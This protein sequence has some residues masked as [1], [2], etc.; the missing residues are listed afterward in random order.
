MFTISASISRILEP[1][2]QGLISSSYKKTHDVFVSKYVLNEKISFPISF[3][4]PELHTHGWS[5]NL[6][7]IPFQTFFVKEAI[8]DLV[9]LDVSLCFVPILVQKI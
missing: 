8:K 2:P 4:S 1:S 7:P 3:Q 5:F 9:F 6:F